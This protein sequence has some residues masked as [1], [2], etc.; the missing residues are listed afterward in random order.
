M[1]SFRNEVQKLDCKTC[2]VLEEIF[3]RLQFKVMCLEQMNLE[4]V[5][6]SA[7]FDVMECH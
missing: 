2:A 3:Q 4:G 5:G 7:H 6:A 1:W